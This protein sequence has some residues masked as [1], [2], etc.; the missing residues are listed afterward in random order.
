MSILFTLSEVLFEIKKQNPSVDFAGLLLNW[1]KVEKKNY[2]F[3]VRLLEFIIT[4]ED[5]SIFLNLF[6]TKII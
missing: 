6:L 2:R 1:Q 3:Q 4:M 5:Q